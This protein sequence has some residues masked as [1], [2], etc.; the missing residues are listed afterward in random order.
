MLN[1]IENELR[2]MLQCFLETHGNSPESAGRASKI[3]VG[4]AIEEGSH[5]IF[6]SGL[7]QHSDAHSIKCAPGEPTRWYGNE[8]MLSQD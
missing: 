2:A 4:E 7:S 3:L 5:I 6:C 8:I 1:N